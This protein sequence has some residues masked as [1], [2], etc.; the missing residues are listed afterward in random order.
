MKG[1]QV[2]GGLQSHHILSDTHSSTMQTYLMLSSNSPSRV[3]FNLNLGYLKCNQ[4]AVVSV[5]MTI[6]IS[7]FLLRIC[8]DMPRATSRSHPRKWLGAKASQRSEPWREISPAL[9]Y[10]LNYPKFRE[11]KGTRKALLWREFSLRNWCDLE[12]L[13][14]RSLGMSSPWP[15]FLSSLL[16]WGNV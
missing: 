4:L 2:C 11:G 10:S 3:K 5:H 6:R 9:C 8:W 16:H 14:K 1:P 13:E 7:L 15:L 12:I